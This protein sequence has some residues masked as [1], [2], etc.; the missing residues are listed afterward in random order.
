[1]VNKLFISL[2]T[3]ILVLSSLQDVHHFG[4]FSEEVEEST[5]EYESIK[6]K[7]KVHPIQSDWTKNYSLLERNGVS[8]RIRSLIV[9]FYELSHKRRIHFVRCP[10]IAT[11]YKTGPPSHSLS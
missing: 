7:N 9:K 10:A 5:R 4:Q 3:T 2:F 8:F 1:M 11:L 6:N